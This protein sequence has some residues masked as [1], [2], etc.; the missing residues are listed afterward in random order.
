M[1][2]V[3]KAT[4]LDAPLEPGVYLWKDATGCVIYVGKAKSLRNRLR[5]YFSGT[6]DAKTAAL[7]QHAASIETIITGNEYEALLLES[8]LVKQHWPKYNIALKDDKSYPVV[9]ISA[10]RFPRIS[11]TRRIVEDGSRYF[12]PFPGV[13][14]VDTL[15][16][17]VEKLYSLRKCRVL[18]ARKTPC[19]Y[20][21][22]GR[23]A[24]PCCGRISEEHYAAILARAARFFSGDTEALV[25]DLTAQMHAEARAL[26]FEKAVD[27]R[28]AI[29]AIENLTQ[30]NAV[31]DFDP[32]SRDYIAWAGEG[33]LVTFTVFSMRQGRMI[34]RELFRTH[35]A[36]TEQESLEIFLASYYTRER[37]PPA[38]IF[39]QEG[40]SD[41]AD[42][43]LLQDW[44][45]R[46]LD[47]AP[48]LSAPHE[49]RH[50]AIT[51]MA[52]Q[53]AL[54]DIRRRVKERGAGPA[55]EELQKALALKTRP[56]RIEGFDIAQLDGKHPVASLISFKNG[57]PDRKNYRVFKLKRVIG[58]V[59]DF[60]AMRE[61]VR[62]RY[63]RL[64]REGGE[65][66]D[67]ILVDGGA[68]QVS[69][70]QGVLDELGLDCDLVGL[71]KQDEELYL[72][73]KSAPV[74]LSRR[75]EGLKVLQFV[76]DETHRFATTLNQK[77]RAKDIA[78][79]RLEAVKGI[80]PHK[81]AALMQ[82]YRSLSAIASADVEALKTH[83][84]CGEKTARALKA[85]ALSALTEFE[86]ATKR[87]NEGAGRLS[88][89]ES[90]GKTL[91]ELAVAD[92][93][94]D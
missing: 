69:A 28:D 1:Y 8:T 92:S 89:R 77:L 93:A 52:R 25:M 14:A 82:Q 11:K 21:H 62:R 38:A 44:F 6:K 31:I 55:L 60:A 70:A 76:R 68:G 56:M 5:S 81:A 47:C 43:A 74:R 45:S 22:I 36:A 9:R 48:E 58:V 24:G 79:S 84:Q 46:N 72:P 88:Y 53:N 71:A 10:E 91:A 80:G 34:G 7:L 18:R 3:L 75:S 41:E 2:A 65:L 15:L 12:G 16:A 26:R 86:A 63:S 37:L 61:A 33:T 39:I 73:H 94:G 35:S 30:K 40:M 13:G 4:A 90:V 57:A 66:P 17:L 87:L 54:E 83:A 29:A 42:R 32:H 27:V 49:K 67:L 23:C 78:F 59:D 20:Y 85:A 51:A 19:M 64:L 50:E